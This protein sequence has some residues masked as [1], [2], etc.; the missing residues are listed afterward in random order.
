M[1]YSGVGV[2]IVTE[3]TAA[4]IEKLLMFRGYGNPSGKFWFVGME[5]GGSSNIEDLLIRTER[6][7]DLEDLAESHS[8]FPSHNMRDLVQTWRRM[9]AIVGHLNGETAWKHPEFARDYQQ[10]HLGR[11][12]GQ[13]YLTDIFPMPKYGI[14]DWPYQHIFGTQKQ[15]REKIFPERANLLAEAYSSA[16]PKPEFVIC[17]GNTFWEYHRKVFDFVDFEPALDGKIEWG[18]VDN[19]VFI[20]TNFFSSR[21]GVTLSF[22]DRLCEFALSKS[23]NE[24]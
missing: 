20:L 8:N 11:P 13:T 14:N 9:S 15:Y 19:T 2:K 4:Q 21:A 7:A 1:D 23:P 12:S 22:V 18:R 17:Y 5:E 24:P 10:F 3:L 16:N 6:F